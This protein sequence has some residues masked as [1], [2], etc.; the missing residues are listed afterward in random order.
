MTCISGLPCIQFCCWALQVENAPVLWLP[1]SRNPKRVSPNT[2][3]L[4]INLIYKFVKETNCGQ[5][6][7]LQLKLRSVNPVIFP[8]SGFGHEQKINGPGERNDHNNQVQLKQ[9]DR[10]L[11]R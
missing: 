4:E 1:F 6:S 10:L 3:G 2:G 8:Y 5:E 9:G 11:Q 7:H